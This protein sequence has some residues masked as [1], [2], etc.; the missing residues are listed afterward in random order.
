MA[1][2]ERE[3]GRLI[4]RFANSLDLKAWDALAD[5]PDLRGTPPATLSITQRVLWSDGD[6]TIHAGIEAPA[7]TT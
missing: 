1:D 2:D 5:C 6:P 3:I 7:R 4:G